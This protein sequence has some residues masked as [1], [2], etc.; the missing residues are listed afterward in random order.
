MTWT[1]RNYQCFFVQLSEYR[2]R[3][4]RYRVQHYQCY[5]LNLLQMAA[6][7]KVTNV[8]SK[9]KL[10][11]FFALYMLAIGHQ[12]SHPLTMFRSVS[13]IYGSVCLR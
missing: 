1:T 12:L 13:P 2:T 9:E 7:L 10:T 3:K 8:W 6:A 11:R 5:E 4:D